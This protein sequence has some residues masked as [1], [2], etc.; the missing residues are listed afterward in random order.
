MQFRAGP[1]VPRSCESPRLLPLHSSTF[2]GILP[3]SRLA[4][5]ALT[6]ST[7]LS[8][9]QERKGTKQWASFPFIDTCFHESCLSM[10][11]PSLTYKAHLTG[12]GVK[13][14]VFIPGTRYQQTIGN[15][16][17]IT[18][19][20]GRR[21]VG[22]NLQTLPQATFTFSSSKVLKPLSSWKVSTRNM[23]FL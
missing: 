6:I 12:W 16:I 19:K 21:F 2:L 1:A 15:F 9:Q 8:G 10:S 3:H 18:K 7:V 5:H 11:W 17:N 20:K 22:E 13:N 23:N 14:V 4:V